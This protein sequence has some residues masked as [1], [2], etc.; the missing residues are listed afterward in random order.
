M[1]RGPRGRRERVAADRA[2]RADSELGRLLRAMEVPNCRC[3][4]RPLP[5]VKGETQERCLAG[6]PPYTRLLLVIFA[7]MPGGVNQPCRHALARAAGFPEGVDLDMWAEMISLYQLQGGFA[8][9]SGDYVGVRPLPRPH[10][11]ATHEAILAELEERARN[12]QELFHPRDLR[13][14]RSDGVAVAGDKR[15]KQKG[16]INETVSP[17]LVDDWQK[18]DLRYHDHRE[19]DI[20]DE[21]LE[22][23]RG[24]D[25][26]WHRAEKGQRDRALHEEV[27][28][29]L[30]RQRRRQDDDGQRVGAFAGGADDLI[31]GVASVRTGAIDS[32]GGSTVH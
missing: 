31:G 11:L 24:S 18:N 26:F 20:E 13:V 3:M 22:E 4:P 21:L 16:L 5:A 2:V 10:T 6:L 30:Q 15:K 1:P 28:S 14:E 7:T 23:M 8:D 29:V 12:G 17:R 27:L 32:S 25:T 19:M 9:D